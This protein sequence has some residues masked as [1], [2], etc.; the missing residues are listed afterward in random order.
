[1]VL[2]PIVA[3]SRIDIYCTSKVSPKIEISN[4]ND[5]AMHKYI[6]NIA[7]RRPGMESNDHMNY[8]NDNKKF[9]RKNDR[10]TN[11]NSGRLEIVQ[12]KLNYL[13]SGGQSINCKD[14]MNRTEN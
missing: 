3:N 6:E 10:Q 11:T 4:G 12:T 1:M 2:N 7:T 13:P 14:E 5:C 9:R 8:G